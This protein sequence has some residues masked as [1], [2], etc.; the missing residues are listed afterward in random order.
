MLF[1]VVWDDSDL[2][3]FVDTRSSSDHG[4]DCTRLL[5]VVVIAL[6]RITQG[7]RGFG[8]FA[9]VVRLHLDLLVLWA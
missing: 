7:A 4:A 8:N 3:S 5:K 2:I 6:I 9:Q 1:F